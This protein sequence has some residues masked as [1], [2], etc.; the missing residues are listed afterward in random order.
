LISGDH[1]ISMAIILRLLEAV[2]LVLVSSQ[3]VG[4]ISKHQCSN[5]QEDKLKIKPY[6][7]QGA[8][9]SPA[10]G[11]GARSNDRG[12]TT[13]A[14]VTKCPYHIDS[15]AANLTNHSIG[16]ATTGSGKIRYF[17][18]DALVGP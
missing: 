2:C 13:S 15:L 7:R 4:S 17:L 11:R 6:K 18:P 14:A 5:F 8:R 9:S 10:N 1:H 12:A 16:C 3:M